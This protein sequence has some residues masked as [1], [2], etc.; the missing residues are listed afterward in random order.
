MA[1][2]KWILAINPGSTSTKIAVYEGKEERLR[3]NIEHTTEEIAKFPTV[4]SQYGM[5]KETVLAELRKA[6]IELCRLDAIAARGAPLPPLQAGAYRIN[7]AMVETLLTRPIYEHASNVAPLIAFELGKELGIPSYIYDGTTVDELSDVAR[8]SGTPLLP[9]RVIA[10]VLNMRAQARRA[11]ESLGKR[12]TEASIIVTHMGG[13]VSAS[14]Q[15]GGRMVDVVAVDEGPFSAD[16]AG[17]LPSIALMDLCY[18]GK[19]SHAGMSR[20][21]RG[22]GGLFAYVGTSSAL[23]VERRIMAGDKEAEV[24]YRAMA[25]QVAKSIGELAT[26]VAGKVD[27]I[28]LTGGIAH[29]GMLTRWV[30]ERVRFLAPVILLP[31]ENELESLAFGV[32]RVVTGEET[33]REYAPK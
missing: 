19:Y 2:R 29:S 1:E 9:R 22:Q 15:V 20:L 18:S 11:A 3:T 30:E 26:V 27:A 24:V 33:A 32:L 28:V 12:Y 23:E 14:V 25:Y 5:R 21:L 10:H 17:G 4:A 8:I 16:R 6:G 13:G 31:G 7:E